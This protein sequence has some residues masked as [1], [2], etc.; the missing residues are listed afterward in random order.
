MKT[1][2]K[3]VEIGRVAQ[4]NYG[5]QEG[6][7][8]VIVDIVNENRALVDGPKIARQVVPIK[9]LRLTK[10]KVPVSR[11]A[12]TGVVR[13]IIQKEGFEKTWA[14]SSLA[15]SIAN[16]TRR[17]NLNDFERFKAMVLKKRVTIALI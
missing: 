9:R 3:F 8:A 12:R 16:R 11:G 15:K 17:A 14:A 4:V 7:I 5:E 13:K 10:F 2:T 6:N 1:F